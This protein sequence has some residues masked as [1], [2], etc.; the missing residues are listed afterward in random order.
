VDSASSRRGSDQVKKRMRREPATSPKAMPLKASQPAW[1][2][3]PSMA[4]LAA[5]LNLAAQAGLF[6]KR[7]GNADAL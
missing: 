1:E 5:D 4:A 7:L 2:W 6:K 3:N